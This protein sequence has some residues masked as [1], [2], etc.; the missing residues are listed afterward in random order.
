[1]TRLL[2]VTAVA[3]ER[4]AVLAGRSPVAG[5]LAGYPVCRASTGAGLV[6]VVAGGV[7]AAAAAVATTALL[8]TGYAAV[9]ATGIAGGLPPAAIGEL[10]VADRVVFADLGAELADGGFAGL[11]E[12]GLGDPEL[13]ADPALAVELTRRTGARLGTVL[14]VNTVTGT[15]Q[16]AARLRAAHPTA[17]AEGMEGAA[18]ALAAARAGVPFGELRAISNPVGPRDRDAW[19]LGTALAALTA[20]FD[21]L[22]SS[23]LPEGAVR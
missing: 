4:D 17:L 7:G 1:M 16:R 12:L 10:V 11:T 13:P 9:L 23:P 15:E 19:Q 20:G 18:V 2:I 3:A 22:L 6:D 8:P 5:E 21:L 14:S